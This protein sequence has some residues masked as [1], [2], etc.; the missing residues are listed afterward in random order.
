MISV[1]EKN[2][3]QFVLQKLLNGNN[4]HDTSFCDAI[5]YNFDKM[6]LSIFINTITKR[7]VKRLSAKP[8][9]Y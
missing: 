8:P 1:Y 2:Q 4:I 7:H 9:P 3:F 5:A 6:E